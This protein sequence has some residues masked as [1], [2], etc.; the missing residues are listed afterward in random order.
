LCEIDV[1]GLDFTVQYA[2]GVDA[3]V[4]IVKQEP[5]L[6]PLNLFIGRMSSFINFINFQGVKSH[7]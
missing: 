7:D 5:V 4:I 2:I 3:L 1:I 6:V